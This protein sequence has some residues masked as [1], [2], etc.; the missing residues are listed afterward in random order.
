MINNGALSARTKSFEGEVDSEITNTMRRNK[1]SIELNNILDEEGLSD[2]SYIM[3]PL[4]TSVIPPDHQNICNTKEHYQDKSKSIKSCKILGPKTIAPSV[5]MDVIGGVH[6]QLTRIHNICN[7]NAEASKSLEQTGKADTW[8]LLALIAKNICLGERDD[9]DGWG[10][11]GTGALAC[12]IIQNIIT[13]YEGRGD[14]Q[15]LATII[16]VFGGCRDRNYRNHQ[17]DTDY[18]ASLS[19]EP[20]SILECLFPDK[21]KRFDLHIHRYGVLLFGW[22]KLCLFAELN[23]HLA[24]T[25]SADPGRHFANLRGSPLVQEKVGNGSYNDRLSMSPN[26]GRE[27]GIGFAPWCTRC[28]YPANQVTNVCSYCQNYAFCC[29]ICTNAVR[30]L[31]TV[32]ITCGH[33][34][35]VEHIIPWFENNTVCPSGCGCSC[36]LNMFS[37]IKVDNSRNIPDSIYQPFSIKVVSSPAVSS[38]RVFGPNLRTSRILKKRVR[39]SEGKEIFGIPFG[40]YCLPCN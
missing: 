14:V 24:D 17:K 35:H 38:R 7:Q 13:Y 29:S 32:C 39:S 9:F 1:S 19:H 27:A 6:K 37:S 34:G 40:S 3:N 4:S 36:T 16:C 8:T 18:S 2:F 20:S 28:R 25:S 23:K 15:M 22:G 10:E 12:D 11:I 33:G 31:F 30:G 21:N 26:F 5:F